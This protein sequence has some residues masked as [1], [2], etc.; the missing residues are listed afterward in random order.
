M[1]ELPQ[2][3][4]TQI[5][6]PQTENPKPKGRQAPLRLLMVGRKI[7]RFP[8]KGLGF[9][10]KGLGFGFPFKGLGFRFR[11]SPSLFR[12]MG[13]TAEDAVRSCDG[14][15]HAPGTRL[16]SQTQIL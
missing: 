6:K 7:S 1:T 13:Q 12:H 14:A 3:R 8:F 10:F 16:T 4:Q 5:P 11:V 15:A 9:P 2:T